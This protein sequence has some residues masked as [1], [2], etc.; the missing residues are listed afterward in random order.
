MGI[1]GREIRDLSRTTCVLCK[2]QHSEGIVASCFS[3]R[4]RSL[5][6]RR[7]HKSITPSRKKALACLLFLLPQH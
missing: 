5:L 1:R 2:S 4:S 7:E 6:Q 3:Q